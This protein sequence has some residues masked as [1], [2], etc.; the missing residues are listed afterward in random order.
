MPCPC[1]LT[2]VVRRDDPR[3]CDYLIADIRSPVIRE[4]VRREVLWGTIRTIPAGRDR[5][6]I[7][8]GDFWSRGRV[9]AVQ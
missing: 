3:L 7:V 6:L 9:G 2:P 1:T 8:P 5:L 4:F